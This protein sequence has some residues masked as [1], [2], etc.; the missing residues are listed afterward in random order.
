MP[1]KRVER[2]LTLSL[3]A[4]GFCI[5]PKR[6]IKTEAINVQ[7]AYLLDVVHQRNEH[8]NHNLNRNVEASIIIQNDCHQT[9]NSK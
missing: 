5:W 9:R 7:I 1:R 8:E 3:E 4:Q 2:R 6:K